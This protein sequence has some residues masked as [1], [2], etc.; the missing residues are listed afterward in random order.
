MNKTLTTALGSALLGG[1]AVFGATIQPA[2]T[3]KPVILSE[4]V[5]LHSRLKEP[6]TLDTKYV[7]TKEMSDAY[8][9]VAEKYGVTTE[10]LANAG[11]TYK[12]QYRRRC[13]HNFYA[14]K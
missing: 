2:D 4:N 5:E 1:G 11:G 9:Q 12:Q 3:T 8:I 13:R 14:N 7:S 10:D 6:P